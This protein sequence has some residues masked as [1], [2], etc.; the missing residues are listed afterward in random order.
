MKKKK[1]KVPVFLLILTVVILMMPQ[2]TFA[3]GE[4]YGYEVVVDPSTTA[5]GSTASVIVRLTDYDETKSSIRGFQIDITNSSEL[6]QN[7]VCTSLV[8][9]KENILSDT[10]AYQSSRDIVRHLYAKMSGTMAYSETDLLK[11]EIPIPNTLTEAGTVSFPFKILIQNADG[12]KYTYESAFEI[13]YAPADEIPDTPEMSVDI[14]WGAM[15]FTYSD[16]TWQPD[17]HTYIG[18]GWQANENS[19]Y[20]TVTNS[21]GSD[22]TVNAVYTTERTDIAGSFSDGTNTITEP[23]LLETSS[24]KNWYLLLSGKP[25]EELDKTVIGSI[26][27]TLE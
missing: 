15:D 23:V 7:A 13:S 26:T 10:A 5:I 4:E 11:V 9:D 1:N 21:G 6:L 8:T 2:I 24:S 20:F 22:V 16:G 27:V 12:G 14:T 3:D 17:S 18:A 19:N 25:T